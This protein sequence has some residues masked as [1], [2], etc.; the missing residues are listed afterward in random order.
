[1]ANLIQN[2]EH[3]TKEGFEKILNIKSGMNLKRK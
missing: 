2:K 1:V 3:L